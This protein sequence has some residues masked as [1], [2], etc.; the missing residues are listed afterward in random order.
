M[1]AV[2]CRWEAYRILYCY[3]W[4]L[5][6]FFLC[7]ALK[8]LL[9]DRSCSDHG[10]SVSGHYLFF[11]FAMWVLAYQHLAQKRMVDQP[12]LRRAFWRRL[13]LAGGSRG[14]GGRLRGLEYAFL[15]AYTAFCWVCTQILADTYFYGY[16]SLRQI[17]YGTALSVAAV[18]GVT[19][20]LEALE[21]RVRQWQG[22]HRAHGHEYGAVEAPAGHAGGGG[23][24]RRSAGHSRHHSSGSSNG[25]EALLS[26]SPSPPASRQSSGAHSMAGQGQGHGPIPNPALGIAHVALFSTLLHEWFHADE[27]AARFYR[28]PFVALASFQLVAWAAMLCSPEARFSWRDV[29]AVVAGHIALAAIVHFKLRLPKTSK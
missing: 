11:T 18:L 17:I 25:A 19:G 13:L 3:L 14:S 10:N 9:G 5:A 21:T 2:G 26:P 24:G 29:A 27:R 1:S 7:G 20:V 12:L 6:A 28:F 8:G 15:V 22:Y 23:S 4:Y 16:H